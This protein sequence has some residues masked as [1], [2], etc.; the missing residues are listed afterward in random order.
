MPKCLFL[1]LEMRNPKG[2]SLCL[3]GFKYIHLRK[4]PWAPYSRQRRKWLNFQCILFE[5]VFS[6][7][8]KKK[9]ALMV[10]SFSQVFIMSKRTI[11]NDCN[12]KQNPGFLQIHL[13]LWNRHGFLLCV[14]FKKLPGSRLLGM[15]VPTML[16]REL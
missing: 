7:K 1:Y 10:I 9:S 5:R 3:K 8:K 14:H 15:T 12:K 6:Q 11:N 13:F 4:T 2:V 16:I